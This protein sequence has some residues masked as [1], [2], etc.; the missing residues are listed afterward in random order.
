MLVANVICALGRCSIVATPARWVAL[1]LPTEKSSRACSQDLRTDAAVLAL[2]S[3]LFACASVTG[4][5]AFLEERVVERRCIDGN[6]SGEGERKPV[7]QHSEY[8]Q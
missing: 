2:F 5:G 7:Q 6:D 3:A 8:S 4:A 1:K